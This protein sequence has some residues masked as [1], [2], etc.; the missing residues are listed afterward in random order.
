MNIKNG[1]NKIVVLLTACISP[2]GMSKTVVQNADERLKQYL[3]AM[4]FYLINTPYD[5]V[6]VEN[7]LFDINL[8]N[9]PRVEYITFDGNN[10]NKLFGKGY[11][12]ALI[13]DHALKNSFF[14]KEADFIIKVTGR[15]KVINIIEIINSL[16]L[17]YRKLHNTVFANIT[18]DVTSCYSHFFIAN[19]LFLDSF[20]LKIVNE[21]NDSKSVYFE[22]VLMKA[23]TSWKI[24]KNHFYVIYNPIVVEGV[25][26]STGENYLDRRSILIIRITQYAKFLYFKFFKKWS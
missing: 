4:D 13:I 2:N 22:H 12:E 6:I 17:P 8:S 18:W 7:T 9:N 14:L 20:F 3:D 19:R 21:I 26:G 1:A 5:I 25:S 23:I 10:Y 16:S 15:L 11:G 24:E